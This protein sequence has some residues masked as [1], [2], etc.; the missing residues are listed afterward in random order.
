MSFF[1]QISAILETELDEPGYRTAQKRSTD[2]LS[3]DY[4]T[5]VHPIK[6]T[7]NTFLFNKRGGKASRLPTLTEIPERVITENKRKLSVSI[8]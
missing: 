8:F 5:T 3:D 6:A 1:L 4:I 2:D 7:D